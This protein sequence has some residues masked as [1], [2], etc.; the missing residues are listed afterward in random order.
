[1]AATAAALVA[2]VSQR[3]IVP[4]CRSGGCAE[5]APPVVISHRST[6]I[7]VT[8]C[9]MNDPEVRTPTKPGGRLMRR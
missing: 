6:A 3:A 9:Q 2:A 7:G 5:N 4:D 8:A 1:M